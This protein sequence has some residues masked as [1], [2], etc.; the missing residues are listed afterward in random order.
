MKWAGNLEFGSSWVAFRGQTAD[1]STHAHAALQV[2]LST[3]G[4]ISLRGTAGTVSGP[5]FLVAP[6]TPHALEATG[7]VTILLIEPQSP[8]ASFV[9]GSKPR[10]IAPLNEAVANLLDLDVP[11]AACMDRLLANVQ[12]TSVLDTRVAA[13]LQ[14][15]TLDTSPAAVA[16]AAGTVGLSTSRLRALAAK[17]L[18]TP[19]ASWMIWRKLERAGKSLARGASLTDA[20]YEA[21]FADQA[22]FTRTMRKVLGITPKMLSVLSH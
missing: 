9:A 17:E 15:L 4:A 10:G 8:I 16:R 11:L 7:I 20:A 14:C 22:H 5:A 12:S 6:G 13:A 1:N 21:G 19:L 2:T 3:E 18:G